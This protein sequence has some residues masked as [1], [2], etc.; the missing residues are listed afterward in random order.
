MA[1]LVGYNNNLEN[2]HQY[3]VGGND[4]SEISDNSSSTPS[5]QEQSERDKLLTEGGWQTPREYYSSLTSS[6]QSSGSD[7]AEGE[8]SDIKT[9][10]ANDEYFWVEDLKNWARYTLSYEDSHKNIFEL[11][12][13]N[14]QDGWVPVIGQ[15]AANSN[16][17]FVLNEP[18]D[19]HGIGKLQNEFFRNDVI[20]PIIQ[21][22]G[23]VQEVKAD[24]NAPII[25]NYDTK[26][27]YMQ[28][29]TGIRL[30]KHF[31]YGI[32]D[33]DNFKTFAYA[34]NYYFGDMSASWE[35]F[36][37]SNFRSPVIVSCPP[38]WRL[39]TGEIIL[40]N[41]LEWNVD[42]G[43]AYYYKMRPGDKAFRKYY[44]SNYCGSAEVYVKQIMTNDTNAAANW[45]NQ[46]CKKFFG[47]GTNKTIEYDWLQEYNRTIDKSEYSRGSGKPGS[48]LNSEL[49]FE[50]H[51]INKENSLKCSF[52]IN[53]PIVTTTERP[54]PEYA[55]KW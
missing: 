16:Y 52:K 4:G 40:C 21:F 36:G 29:V 27:S 26:K 13:W 31:K 24:Y 9:N 20:D 38:V 55:K 53:R 41:R 34:T 51:N 33:S 47:D 18:L 32:N 17:I 11:N 44:N 2:F 23:I 14:G 49:L 39:P 6:S 46:K 48:M 8:A 54:A 35:T 42:P 12:V 7:D 19:K 22:R 25:P 15:A 10:T 28:V 50:Q 43:H 5:K 45:V 30:K 1:A 37:Q 3:K